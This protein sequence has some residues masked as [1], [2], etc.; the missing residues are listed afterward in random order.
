[1]Q[2]TAY[3]MCKQAKDTECEM[4]LQQ[5]TEGEGNGVW[6]CLETELVCNEGNHGCGD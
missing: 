2:L 3:K 4:I 5:Q 1:M 6:G